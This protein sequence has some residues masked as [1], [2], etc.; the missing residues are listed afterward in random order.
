M[1][2]S[3]YYTYYATLLLSFI[4]L[5]LGAL[6]SGYFYWP[7]AVLIPL[8]VLGTWDVLQSRHSILRNYPILAHM[9]FVFEGIRPELRQYFFESNL[10][11]TPFSRELRTLV[12][13]RAKSEEDAMPFGTELDVY[14]EDY[15]WINHSMAPCS[16][17]EDLLRV[18]IGGADCSRRYSASLYNI[19]AMSFGSISASAIRAMNKGAKKGNF[20]HDTGEGGISRYHREFGGDLI[21]EIGSGYFGCRNDDGTFNPKMFA[22]QAAGDQ[23]KMVEIKLSQGAKPGHGGILPA[24]KVTQEIAETRRV[25]IGVDCVSPAGHKAF[26]TPIELME[27]IAEIRELSGGKP[28]GFKLCIGHPWEFMSLCKAVLETDIKPD[29]IV[30][31]GAEGGTGAAP[32][33][34][35]NHLGTPLRQGLSFVHNVLVGANLRDEIRVGASGKIVSAFDI[36]AALCLGADWCNSARGFM[37]A[38]GCIQSRSC[39]TNRCPVGVA[40]Q[41]EQRQRALVVSDKAERI[42]NFHRHTL[43]ALTEFVAASGL[44]HPRQLQ[45]QHYYLREG[46][47]AVLPADEA[48]VW[49]KPGQLLGSAERHVYSDHWLKADPKRFRI[50]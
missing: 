19:S 48:L 38:V 3:R 50:V 35:S 47:R 34:F 10:S 5:V 4:F 6:E 39:H 46:N 2:S 43:K 16:L 29:F 40:T 28:T 20:A 8:A 24:A 1:S 12:Y 33:E 49:L 14:A 27:F 22:E 26:S 36:A 42:Y 7:L 11:G 23:V 25:P 44:E 37:F 18:E 17:K 30:I 13:E 45:P 32:I 31:D 41:D 9:R 15:R 21:W